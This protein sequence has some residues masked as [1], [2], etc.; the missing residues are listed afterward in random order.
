[1][2]TQHPLMTSAQRDESIRAQDNF[3]AIIGVVDGASKEDITAE[4]RRRARECHPDKHPHDLQK[5]THVR[6]QQKE[7]TQLVNHS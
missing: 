4:Y 1:M 5:G 2:A 7:F 6:S 3:F